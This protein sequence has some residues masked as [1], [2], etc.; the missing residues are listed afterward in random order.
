VRLLRTSLC[1]TE[2]P[3]TFKECCD[4]RDGIIRCRFTDDKIDFFVMTAD[5]THLADDFFD[6]ISTTYNESIFMEETNLDDTC[7]K[8]PW[9]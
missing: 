1:E 4:P 3:K 7:F 5:T 2:L 6:Y 8:F 9:I